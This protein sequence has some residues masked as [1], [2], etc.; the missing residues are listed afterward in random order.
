M[1]KEMARQLAAGFAVAAL[2]A[3][4]VNIENSAATRLLSPFGLTAF[5]TSISLFIYSCFQRA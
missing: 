3:L 1:G 2:I 5:V 4:S